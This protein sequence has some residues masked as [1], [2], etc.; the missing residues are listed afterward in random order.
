MHYLELLKQEIGFSQLKE[1]IKKLLLDFKAAAYYGC[2]LLRPFEEMGFDDKERPTLF[3]EFLG[4][5]CAEAS[6]FPFKIGCCG[7]FQFVGSPEV[8]TE[9]AYKIL[10][11]AIRGGRRWSLLLVLLIRAENV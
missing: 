11:S 8:A 5:L 2:M 7:S 4:T 10:C 6:D 9:C 1:K 3:E